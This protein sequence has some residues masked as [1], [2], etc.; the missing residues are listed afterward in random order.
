MD[1][2]KWFDMQGGIAVK[3]EFSVSWKSLQVALLCQLDYGIVK[4]VPYLLIRFVNY[5]EQEPRQIREV[6]TKIDEL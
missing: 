1:T 2:K 6:R 3:Q 4:I 5:A